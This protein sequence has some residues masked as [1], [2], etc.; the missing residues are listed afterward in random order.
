MIEAPSNTPPQRDGGSDIV[1]TGSRAIT[2]GASAPTP[3]T[4]A[5]SEQLTSANPGNLPDAVNQLPQ[6][7]GSQRPTSA[8]SA[9]TTSGAGAN[10]LALR[11]LGPSR[12]LVL[13]DG[14]RIVPT[15]LIGATDANLI[16]QGLV[17]R[18]DV[19]TGGA[20]AAYG[21]DA[22]AGVANFVLDSQYKGVKGNI[23]GGLSSHSDAGSMRASIVAGQSFAEDRLH[24]LLSADYFDQKGIDLD[25]HGRGWAEAGYGVI[26]ASATSAELVVAP[27]VRDALATYGGLVLACQ[28]AGAACPIA[29]M[30]FLPDGSLTAYRQGTNVSSST[31]SGGDGTARRTNLLPAVRT[32]TTFSR[33][34]FDVSDDIH[35]FAEGSYGNVHARYLGSVPANVTS[36][37]ATIYADNAY[38]PP[39]VRA[40]M[41]DNGVAS[42]TLARVN[43]DLGYNY[44]I[45]NTE[46]KRILGGIDIALGGS[47]KLSS[48]AQYGH[49]HLQIK[50]TNDEIVDN[51]YNAIDAV[52]N[53]ADGKIV[54]RSTLLNTVAG[55]GCVP[56]NL[57][58]D[59]A[60]T[61]GGSQNYIKGT[62]VSDYSIG[63]TVASLEVRGLISI[64]DRSVSV[65]TG[66]EYRRETGVLTVDPL[67]SKLR[68]GDGIR[69]YPASQ[70]NLLGDYVLTPPQPLSGAFDVKET[71]MEVSIPLLKDVAVFR[72]LD[73]DGAIRYADYSSVGGAVSWK[74]GASWEPVSDL[75]F[76]ST[77]SRDIRAPNIQERFTTG[78]PIIGLGVNDPQHDN[79]RYAVTQLQIGNVDLRPETSR[80]TAF[81]VVLTPSFLRGFSA[82]VDYYDITIKNVIA[83]P[84]LQQVV[85]ACGLANCSLVTRNADGTINTVITPN[86]NLAQ[87]RTRGEDYEIDYKSRLEGIGLSG[88]LSIRALATHIRTLALTVGTSTIDRVGDLNVTPTSTPAGAPAW[89]GSV[90]A[91]YRGAHIH[92]FAQERYIGPGQLDHTL[93][94]ANGGETNIP[95]V[96]YTDLTFGY[97]LPMQT[98]TMEIFGT[99]NNLFDQ[100][101]PVAPSG[102]ATTPRASNGAIYDLVGR[103]IT[104]GVRFAL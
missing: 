14:R 71:F 80:T 38:L 12:T 46:T 23:Q 33:V 63:Q 78:T 104:V 89:S 75:R 60:T 22:V 6:F 37:A 58:G 55:A 49:T 10:L 92:A 77:L 65:A 21:S 3:V 79:A 82:S 35:L 39:A 26:G 91:D 30:Q 70:K 5:S 97:M 101:P 103:Y 81:G 13:L 40:S 43:R 54:C 100:D 41:A 34:T 90:S 16:P 4:V 96:F 20:S 15:T 93:V 73:V 50:A 74:V 76:R 72:S 87:L 62:T 32:V 45:N 83:Q 59:G 99:V 52:V 102:A 25:Y 61:R 64:L 98:R 84:S 69:G 44:F 19:V 57:F 85:D 42:F 11:G 95:R 94:Y 56:I 31:M 86:Q 29:R 47:W 67:S 28:P 51:F 48:Y 17:K 1:V 27:D 9:T 8:G 7:R 88:L 36:A 53:P 68:T 66:F 2:S 18:V 24:L